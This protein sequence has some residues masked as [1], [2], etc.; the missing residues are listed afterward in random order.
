MPSEIR[1][2]DGR[3]DQATGLRRMFAPHAPTVLPIVVPGGGQ[4]A[5]V[6]NLCIA[7][8]RGGREVV[9]IDATPGEVALAMG[10]RQRY[11]MAHVQAGDKSLREIVL[12]P[13]PRLRIVPAARALRAV[14]SLDAWL[15]ALAMCLHPQP[16]L[17][18][19]YQR[20]AAAPFDGDVLMAPPPAADALM[21]TYAELKRMRHSRGRIHL[22]VSRAADEHGARTL[23]RA[24]DQTAQRYLGEGVDWG[25]FIPHDA[26]L[27]RA[28]AAARPVFDID[29]G[30][31]SAR[32]LMALGR[33]LQDW[34]LPRLRAVAH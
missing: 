2:V 29:V 26:S 5:L 27:R 19:V 30:A 22:V 20:V 25:G 23:H 33:T 4:G 3:G 15:G 34:Q 24:L 17:F 18:V 13:Q 9:V 6:A 32:A 10:L 21:R 14:N 8:T 12:A 7:L 28:E 11:E 1:A 31:S 16:D